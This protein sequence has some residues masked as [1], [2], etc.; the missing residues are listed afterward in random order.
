MTTIQSITCPRCG[1]TSYNTNDVRERYCGYC[2]VFLDDPAP[3]PRGSFLDWQSSIVKP[4]G[5]RMT[6]HFDVVDRLHS[7]QPPAHTLEGALEFLLR[8]VRAL[9]ADEAAAGLLLKPGGDNIVEYN[10]RMVSAS[11][12]CY[13]TGAIVKVLTDVPSTNGPS[14]QD[15]GEVVD[16]DR[17]VAV[18]G[19]SEPPAAGNGDGNAAVHP[20]TQI[21]LDRL[22][23][24][25]FE[26]FTK[27]DTI[28]ANLNRRLD[29]LK[30]QADA[31]TE[32]IQQQID[33]VVKDAEKTLGELR[34]VI[35]GLKRIG[36]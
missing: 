31:D 7:E 4:K 11:R 19:S 24:L 32:K 30:A 6:N 36:L 16:A 12:I 34:P 28:E 1:R 25:A 9:P 22:G 23:A 33:H 13:P 3:P 29:E 15:D 20:E 26:A 18:I 14:W 27:M 21:I 10:G 35:D 8:V 5:D 17:Y 2:H